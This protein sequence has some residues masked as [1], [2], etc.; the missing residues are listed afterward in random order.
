MRLREQ[1]AYCPAEI[2]KE[3]GMTL[4]DKLL[5]LFYLI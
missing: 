4:T 1:F 5:Q 2:Y 3:D